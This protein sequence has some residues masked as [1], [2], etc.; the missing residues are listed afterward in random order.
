MKVLAGI[1]LFAGILTGYHF[2][3]SHTSFTYEPAPLPQTFDEYYK[4]QLANSKRLSARPN[5]EEKLIQY[6]TKTPIAILYIHGY[7][8]SRA[9]G[10]YVI[11]QVSKKFSY[12]TYYLRLPGFGTKPED[13]GESTMR[14]LLTESTRALMMMEKLGDKVMVV[15]TSM[16]GA[17]ATYLAATYPEKIDSLVLCSPSYAFASPAARLVTFYPLFK[18]MSI[19]SPIRISSAPVPE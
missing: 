15:G 3:M 9:E 14:D 17:I 5:N 6:S 4:N 10:E 16:G 8:A 19:V 1:I 12:N 13:M 18:F 11:D 2:I 7:G